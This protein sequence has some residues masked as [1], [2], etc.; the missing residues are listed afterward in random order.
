MLSLQCLESGRTFYRSLVDLELVSV[1]DFHL[2]S[3]SFIY[4][5]SGHTVSI[6]DR[7][8]MKSYF[9]Y[10]FIRIKALLFMLIRAFEIDLA[11]SPKDVGSRSV[12]ILR[13]TLL[14]D[15][16]NSNQMPILVRPVS[17]FY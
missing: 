5:F 9:A 15:S 16:K 11:V 2:W 7:V 4:L 14:T 17:N 8:L 10:E 13:P 12:G 1:L 6:P 3:E